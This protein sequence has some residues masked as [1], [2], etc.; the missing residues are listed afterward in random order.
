MPL[1]IQHMHKVFPCEASMQSPEE[2]CIPRAFAFSLQV[3][4]WSTVVKPSHVC[5]ITKARALDA[6]RQSINTV[7]EAIS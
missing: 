4:R 7:T 6:N 5:T 3:K 2:R 1:E